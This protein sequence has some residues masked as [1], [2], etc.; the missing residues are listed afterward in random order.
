[1]DGTGCAWQLE[2]FEV[3]R[4]QVTVTF[5]GKQIVSDAGLLPVRQ[6][7]ILSEAARRLPDPRSQLFVTHSAERILT[8]LVDQILA[9]YPDGNDAQLLRDDPLFKTIAGVDPREETSLA[10]GSTIN[11]FQHALT[12]READEPIAER[13]VLFEVRRAQTERIHATN[14]FLVDVFVRTRQQPLESIIVDLDP[15]DDPTHGKQQSSLF[16]G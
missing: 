14:R 8:Q 12:R 4:Q 2:L 16:H 6:L 13:E 3:N 11:R 10:S 15:T 7:A 5:D 1:M 9:G